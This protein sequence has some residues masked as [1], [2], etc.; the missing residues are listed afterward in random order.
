MNI[1][2]RVDNT[3]PTIKQVAYMVGKDFYNGFTTYVKI[4]GVTYS[5]TG[6]VITC[7]PVTNFSK[8]VISRVCKGAGKTKYSKIKKITLR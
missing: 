1:S 6:N 4:E 2:I 3:P 5:L 7:D 8:E